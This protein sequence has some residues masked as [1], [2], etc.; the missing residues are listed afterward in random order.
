MQ[1]QS[2]N[3]EAGRCIRSSSTHHDVAQRH[4]E[5]K[6]VDLH[7]GHTCVNSRK[8]AHVWPGA[9]PCTA[10]YHQRV[11]IHLNADARC[12]HCLPHYLCSSQHVLEDMQHLTRSPVQNCKAQTQKLVH[13]HGCSM[14]VLGCDLVQRVLADGRALVLGGV[15]V[16]RADLYAHSVSDSASSCALKHLHHCH[17]AKRARHALYQ[18]TA[19]TWWSPAAC[20]HFL[21]DMWQHKFVCTA[22]T[23]AACVQAR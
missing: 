2:S 16:L 12:W 18:R 20:W 19:Q 15:A 13:L 4:D 8:P 14:A 10:F 9:H 21:V 3:T 17:S 1:V 11:V 6:D 22:A 5:D 23:C 7:A